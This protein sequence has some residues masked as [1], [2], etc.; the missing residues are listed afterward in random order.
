[1]TAPQPVPA[2]D[3]IARRIKFDRSN[4]FQRDLKARVQRYFRMSRRSPRDVPRM[5]LKTA[6]IVG[7]C[8]AS[9][10]LLV[11]VAA[12]WWQAVPLAVSLGLAMAAIGFNLGHDGGHRAYSRHR[13]I[14]K[15]AA[16]SLD[17]L[18]GSS[19]I[20]AHKHNTLHHTYANITGHDADLD[21]GPFVRMSPHQKRSRLHRIQH[22]YTWLLYGFLPIKWHLVD[23]FIDVARG[24]M[25][26]HRFARPRGWD[27]TV[28]IG[29]K[30]TFFALGFVVPALFHPIWVVALLYGL[31]C[32]CQGLVMSV[33]FQLAHVV[34]EAQFPLPDAAT[35]RVPNQ[36]AVHQVETTVNFARHNRMLS[37]YVGG[38][39]FQIEHHLFPG[40]CHVHYPK[41]SRIVEK[42]SRRAGIR[43]RAHATFLAGLCSHFR[44]LREMGRPVPAG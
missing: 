3:D 8:L 24:R 34:G 11:F 6:I 7:W 1:M 36:W 37:W 27:L 39:N 4:A 21:A 9:Y 23:D 18:G 25:G 33:V 40:I 32:W 42:A 14:N 44:W 30:V 28:F 26:P 22:I 17:L 43:Y 16:M 20:W 29:G 41:L 31:A 2:I 12:T 38:L 13:W 35:G 19:Y 5:Y 15:L 10:V